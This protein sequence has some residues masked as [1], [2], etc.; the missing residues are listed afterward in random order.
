MDRSDLLKGYEKILIEKDDILRHQL[1]KLRNLDFILRAVGS[2]Q[3][4]FGREEI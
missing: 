1:E 2:P 3:I 4:D